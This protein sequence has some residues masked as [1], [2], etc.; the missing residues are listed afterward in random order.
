MSNESL[1][2]GSQKGKTGGGRALEKVMRYATQRGPRVKKYNRIEKAMGK[3]VARGME[4]IDASERIR[5]R[6]R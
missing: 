6:R 1:A 3:P 4:E 5:G 2:L